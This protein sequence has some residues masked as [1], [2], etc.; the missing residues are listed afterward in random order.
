MWLNAF[1]PKVGSSTSVSPHTIL[2]GVN[3]DY[4]KHYQLK[5]GIITSTPI[6]HTN[7]HSRRQD[8]RSYLFR[9]IRKSPRGLKVSGLSTG[10]KITR[11]I[12]T[13][14]PM[15]PAVIYRMNQIGIA[16]GPP[17]LLTFYDHKVKSIGYDD[18]NIAGLDEAAYITRFD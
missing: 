18:I 12:W 6:K 13:A 14:F 4:N 11:I 10:R 2:T 15:P 17:S 3:F 7:Q 9:P 8:G 16:E 1:P 5:L